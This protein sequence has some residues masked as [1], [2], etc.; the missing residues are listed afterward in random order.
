MFIK[1]NYVKL[2]YVKSETLY[3][4]LYVSGKIYSMEMEK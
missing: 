1:L 2:K 4:L 3:I